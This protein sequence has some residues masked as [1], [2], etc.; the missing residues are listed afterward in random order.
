[1]TNVGPDR[2]CRFGRF[3]CLT[4]TY[5]VAVHTECF[6]TNDSGKSP[7]SVGNTSA[8]GWFSRCHVSFRGVTNHKRVQWQCLIWEDKTMIWMI[9]LSLYTVHIIH[10]H[11]CRVE[12]LFFPHQK[13]FGR[14]GRECILPFLRYQG[15]VLPLPTKTW[16]PVL[17]WKNPFMIYLPAFFVIKKSTTCIGRYSITFPETNPE[18]WMVG[19]R[20]GFLFGGRPIFKGHFSFKER[21]IHRSDGSKIL[22]R[23][24]P[25]HPSGL[26]A[27]T[28]E[29]TTN[30]YHRKHRVNPPP[31]SHN[32]KI[33][34]QKLTWQW[35]DNHEWRSIS[36]EQ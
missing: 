34:T 19:K 31:Q 26:P 9:T 4:W 22:Y 17:P 25:P 15:H 28:R 7:S 10:H 11:Y 14:I 1:M 2:N 24:L 30:K 6:S 13:T 18:K 3:W 21:T 8:N 20:C 36:C 12:P 5:S 27:S 23:Y 33:H 16:I 29:F 35:K 32:L